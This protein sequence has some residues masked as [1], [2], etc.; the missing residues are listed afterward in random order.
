MFKHCS[1]YVH[2]LCLTHSHP[3]SELC[4]MFYAMLHVQYFMLF[5]FTLLQC[6]HILFSF[7]RITNSEDGIRAGRGEL[8]GQAW[9]CRQRARGA[10]E[11]TRR[12]GRSSKQ[13]AKADIHSGTHPIQ[14]LDMFV[15]TCNFG[16]FRGSR[17][18]QKPSKMCPRGSIWGQ[19]QF[20]HVMTTLM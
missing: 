2:L 5:K 6:F 11:K 9:A 19:G 7:C 8:C 16:G 15:Y 14:F 4:F 17:L 18:A 10:G 13:D 12:G 3:H 1:L 20:G